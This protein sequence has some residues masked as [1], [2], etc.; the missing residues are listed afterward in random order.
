M[1]LEPSEICDRPV[2]PSR[3]DG[4]DCRAAASTWAQAPGQ[5][6][7]PALA[8]RPQSGQSA[9]SVTLRFTGKLSSAIMPRGTVSRTTQ[10][11]RALAVQAREVARA[12][13]LTAPRPSGEAGLRPMPESRN[14]QQDCP[15]PAAPPRSLPSPPSRAGSMPC[16][17]AFSTNGCNSSG[18][19]DSPR[20]LSDTSIAYRRRAPKRNGGDRK[21][22]THQFQLFPDGRYH[23]PAAAETCAQE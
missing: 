8:H 7:A 20:M 17:R 14:A 19:N 9:W 11:A 12:K 5:N 3:R 23:A 1:R 21:Q 2:G 4:H 10:A 16:F 13:H 22:R 18:G 6:P 15:P